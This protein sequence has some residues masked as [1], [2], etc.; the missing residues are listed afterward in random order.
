MPSHA[1]AHAM[2]MPIGRRSNGRGDSAGRLR[3]IA[4]AGLVGASPKTIVDRFEIEGLY[5]NALG[6]A[7][8]GT[9]RVSSATIWL[10]RALAAEKPVSGGFGRVFL[11]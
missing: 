5:C 10:S 9:K 3:W 2:M 11:E 1:I 7:S 4:E 8:T 6:C